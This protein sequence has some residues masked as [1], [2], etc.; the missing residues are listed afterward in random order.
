M[1][2]STSVESRSVHP[3]RQFLTQG[4]ISSLSQKRN[5]PSK[6]IFLTES[7]E[8]QVPEQASDRLNVVVLCPQ[9]LVFKSGHQRIDFA[10]LIVLYGILIQLNTRILF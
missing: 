8:L 2:S 4:T 3:L 10:I 1:A 9:M 6:R 7:H 5:F